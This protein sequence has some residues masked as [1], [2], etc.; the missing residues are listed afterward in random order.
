MA[1][2]TANYGLHQ[3][4]ASDN[5]LRTDFNTDFGIIDGALNGLEADKIELVTGTYAGNGAASQAVTLGFQPKMV[6]V[7]GAWGQVSYSHAYSYGGMAFPNQP[8]QFFELAVLEITTSGFTAY[9]GSAP[10][11]AVQCNQSGRNYHYMALK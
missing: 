9:E 2:Y 10:G 11:Y 7:A 5:F 3:W 6:L 1:T 4:E 8:G